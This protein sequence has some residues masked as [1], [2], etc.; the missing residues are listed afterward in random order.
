MVTSTYRQC[1]LVTHAECPF[2]TL[3]RRNMLDG[4][5]CTDD[6]RSRTD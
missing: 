2:N 5:R 1:L 4:I 6:D 3:F